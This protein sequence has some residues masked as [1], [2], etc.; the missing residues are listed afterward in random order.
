[1][2]TPP[3]PLHLALA[4]P[5]GDVEESASSTFYQEYVAIVNFAVEEG[6]GLDNNIG[7]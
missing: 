2:A 3:P 6:N 4:P 1:M 5:I 7:V